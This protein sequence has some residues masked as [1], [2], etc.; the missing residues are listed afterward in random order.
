M[1]DALL[2]L[3]Y[4][5]PPCGVD[6]LPAG[7]KKIHRKICCVQLHM[8]LLSTLSLFKADLFLSVRLY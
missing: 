3:L 1:S 4:F 2:A 7:P 6:Y 8:L 5:F